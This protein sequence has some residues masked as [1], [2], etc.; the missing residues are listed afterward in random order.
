[1]THRVF[2]LLDPAWRP[3]PKG[4]G[5]SRMRDL[6]ERFAGGLGGGEVEVVPGAE[7]TVRSTLREALDTVRARMCSTIRVHPEDRVLA[8]ADT[9]ERALVAEGHDL[10]APVEARNGVR[11]LVA[12]LPG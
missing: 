5:R 8:A 9:V 3:W 1:V 10:D 6:M 2:P 11:F 7:W 4:E 12:R